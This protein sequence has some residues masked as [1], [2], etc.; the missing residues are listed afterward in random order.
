MLHKPGELSGGEQQRVALGRAFVMK[1]RLILADEPTGNLDTETGIKVFNL[2]KDL[3]HK[4][5]VTFVVAT[6][7]EDIARQADRKF[8]LKG[9]ILQQEMV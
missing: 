1:P 7:N 9:G 2:M 6:H 3:S 4:N 5:Q 8:R